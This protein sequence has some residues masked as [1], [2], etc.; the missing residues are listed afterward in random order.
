VAGCCE[1]SNGSYFDGGCYIQDTN[2]MLKQIPFII[3]LFKVVNP[4][5]HISTIYMVQRGN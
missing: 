2:E 5:T 4:H 3:D 1:H